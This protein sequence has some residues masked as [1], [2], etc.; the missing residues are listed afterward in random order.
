MGATIRRVT[1]LALTAGWTVGLLA[2]GPHA[3]EKKAETIAVKGCV[4]K[5]DPNGSFLLTKAAPVTLASDTAANKTVANQS[6]TPAANQYRLNGPDSMVAPY[7]GR[8]VQ[9]T[10]TVEQQSPSSSSTKASGPAANAPAFAVDS[11]MVLSATC[12]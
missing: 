5:A 4:A 1:C 12:S 6:K 3:Q 7:V 10:G 8:E 9:L 2:Q 11:V